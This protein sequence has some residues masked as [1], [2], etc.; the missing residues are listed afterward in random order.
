MRDEWKTDDS[1]TRQL[2]GTGPW[3]L[4]S[5]PGARGEALRVDRVWFLNNGWMH[6]RKG[7]GRWAADAANGGRVKVK[8]C[9]RETSMKL[10]ASGGQWKLAPYNEAEGG[11][12]G[13]LEADK[14][15]IAAWD[16]P[17]SGG[18]GGNGAEGLAERIVGSGPY[19]GKGLSGEA[20]FLRAGVL[21][22]PGGAFSKYTWWHAMDETRVRWATTEEAARDGGGDSLVVPFSDCFV[23]RM[24]KRGV[25]SAVMGGGS[26]DGELP[27]LY[28]D[29]VEAASA[30]WI[31]RPAATQ[32]AD[33]CA[34]LSLRRLTPSDKAASPL[35]RAVEGCCGWSWAGFG[36]LK[37]LAGGQLV[38]PWGGGVWGAPP[39]AQG[40]GQPALLAEFAG[41]KHLLRARVGAG[42]AVTSMESRRCA[43]NDPAHVQLT[44]GVA[45]IGA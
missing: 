6:T 22:V 3:T 41:S 14:K 29:G 21:Q 32:C 24:P 42:G 13:V 38:S 28:G 25:L 20:Y 35:A 12:A 5:T 19:R 39:E 2:L 27:A 8:V 10:T 33:V 9:G 4:S 43:D 18:G 11:I 23:I 34:G 17:V 16:R 1:L 40:A 37:F 44:D 30:E 26:G 15:A 45:K 7:H 36:G 31:L